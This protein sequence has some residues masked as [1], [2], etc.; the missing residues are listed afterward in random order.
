MPFED[1]RL[2][3]EGTSMTAVFVLGMHRCGTS[4]VSGLLRILGVD[5][6][7]DSDLMPPSKFNQKGFFEHVGLNGINVEVLV[8]FGGEWYAPP[9][10]LPGWENSDLLK[11]IQKRAEERVE[12]G[13]GKSELWG[14]KDPRT[15]LTFP[16]W[17]KVVKGPIKTVVVSRNPI[18]AA[19]SL[20]EMQRILASEASDLWFKH[21][22]AAFLGS[23]DLPRHVVFYEDF[24]EDL[25]KEFG[26]LAAFVERP[27]TDELM[28]AARQFVDGQLRHYVSTVADVQG[29][30]GISPKTRKA[31]LTIR[32]FVDVDRGGGL[33]AEDHQNI[34]KILA[35]I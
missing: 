4:L 12:A 17:R 20:Q 21:M 1:Q 30:C 9:A 13:F 7:S 27:M 26:R 29:G 24:L 14:F 22:V 6:G 23:R 25:G 18:D 32:S 3:E 19:Q 15:C 33:Q 16:F 11:D 8:K 35:G 28:K 31:Y 10:L 34:E 5:F 2:S